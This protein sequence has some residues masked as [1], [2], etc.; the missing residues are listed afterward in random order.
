MKFVFIIL[1]TFILLSLNV[2][3][4]LPNEPKKTCFSELMHELCVKHLKRGRCAKFEKDERTRCE[5]MD[6]TSIKC[7]EMGCL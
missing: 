2:Y 5:I 7:K 6:D 3:S 4:Y 1:S